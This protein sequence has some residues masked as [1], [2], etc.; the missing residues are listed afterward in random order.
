M[1]KAKVWAG[2][3]NWEKSQ[4]G[5]ID[6]CGLKNTKSLNRIL[7]KGIEV[8]V[9]FE[10]TLDAVNGNWDG[11]SQEYYGSSVVKKVTFGPA[12]KKTAPN[13]STS[14]NTEKECL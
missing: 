10:I 7:K 6:L 9:T 14:N 2:P 8:K 12:K 3:I 11:V 13:V 4:S 5:M 1:V